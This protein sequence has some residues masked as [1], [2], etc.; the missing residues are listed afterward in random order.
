MRS[1]RIIL[2]PALLSI[3]SCFIRLQGQTP[4]AQNDFHHTMAISIKRA[5]ES[6]V[7]VQ[8]FSGTGDEVLWKVGTGFIIDQ[9][10]FVATR[11]SIVQEGDSIVVTLAN[12]RAFPAWMMDFDSTTEMVILKMPVTGLVPLT[13]GE[14]SGIAENSQLAV[15]GNSLGVFPSITLGSYR[16]KGTDGFMLMNGLIPPGNCGSPV[17]D[18]AGRLVGVFVGRV[19]EE[20]IK[21]AEKD[22]GAV[23]PAELVKESLYRLLGRMRKELGW[24]G[25]TVVDLEGDWSG[26]GVIVMQL[27]LGGPAQRAGLCQGDTVI[28]FE[29]RPVENA[30]DLAEWVKSSMPEQKVS[31]TLKKGA[32]E[33][34]MLVRVGSRLEQA[35]RPNI[36]RMP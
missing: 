26:R 24:V 23:L 30:R 29:G 15:L 11:N 2:H 19:D 4:G 36:R 7:S 33:I 9:D 17:L 20:N 25:L 1:E 27:A 16:G 8:A 32:R 10:G 21:A 28:G 5:Q 31:F 18:E 14:S 6:V 34:S 13:Y 22:M 12:G 3:F 35:K